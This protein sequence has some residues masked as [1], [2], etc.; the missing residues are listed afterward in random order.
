M[1]ITLVVALT[2]PGRVIGVG[3][4]LP[5]RLPDDLKRFKQITRGHAVVM[6]RRTWESIGRALPD[7]RNV[8]VTR[9][10]N[11]RVPEGVIVAADLDDALRAVGEGEV[12]VIGGGEIFREALPRADRIWATWVDA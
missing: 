9:D 5:W 3:N 11:Y 6:G 12:M 1:S 10:R 2:K 8:V 7:R 4:A